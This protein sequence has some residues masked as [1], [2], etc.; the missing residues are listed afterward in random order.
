MPV[1]LKIDWNLAY[2]LFT[3]GLTYREIANQVGCKEVSL[4]AHGT[5]NN[6]REKVALARQA[7]SAIVQNMSQRQPE[8][9]QRR[10]EKWVEREIVAVERITDAL[11]ATPIP[12]NLKGIREVVEVRAMNGN[13]VAP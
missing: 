12:S 6:W 10:A 13:A 2:D 1:K 7:V 8:T 11:D 5:R 3:R 9:V 4:R